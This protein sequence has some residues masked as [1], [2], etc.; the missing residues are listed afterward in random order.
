MPPANNSSSMFI[1]LSTFYKDCYTPL[2]IMGTQDNLEARSRLTL[3]EL[4][5]EIRKTIWTYALDRP[6]P[7][8]SFCLNDP[9][10]EHTELPCNPLDH[11]TSGNHPQ[12]L[13]YLPLPYPLPLQV[14]KQV[15]REAAE[16]WCGNKTV[17]FCGWRCMV[18]LV[19]DHK[20]WFKVVLGGGAL[21]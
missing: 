11:R 20:S 9:T 1:H 21:V 13:A 6:F 15:H 16:V 14:N 18:A 10:V 3:L 4:P 7:S 8:P 17:T 5:T 2:H 19:V 12:K